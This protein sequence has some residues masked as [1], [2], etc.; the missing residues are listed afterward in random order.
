MAML[1]VR[2]KMGYG[3]IWGSKEST[4][5]AGFIHGLPLAWGREHRQ[6]PASGRDPSFF[7]V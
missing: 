6:A 3:F 1:L 2:N 5:G 4:Q 7:Q